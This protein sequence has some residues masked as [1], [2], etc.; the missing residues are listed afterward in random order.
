MNRI[1]LHIMRMLHIHARPRNNRGCV[2][3]VIKIVYC[4]FRILDLILSIRLK[5][6]KPRL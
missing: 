4:F 3:K 6:F 2:G 5:I 1:H